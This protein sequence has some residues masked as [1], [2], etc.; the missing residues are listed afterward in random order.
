MKTDGTRT[1]GN[2]EQSQTLDIM[3]A[4]DDLGAGQRAKEFCDRL[5]RHLGPGLK[6]KL[7]VWKISLFRFPEISRAATIA[8]ESAVAIIFAAN[9][10]KDLSPQAK[11]WIEMFT[12]KERPNRN[13]ALVALLHDISHLVIDLAPAG[14]S[15]SRLARK[16]GMAFFADVLVPKEESNYS[17][18]GIYEHAFTAPTEAADASRCA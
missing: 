16:A 14:I 17:M 7:S 5:S 15:L 10:H 12:G 1:D 6:L 3:I 8:A 13:C 11:A 2:E 9:G 4:Y 18:E